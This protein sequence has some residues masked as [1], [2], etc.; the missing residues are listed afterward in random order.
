MKNFSFLWLVGLLAILS[1]IP[2]ITQAQRQIPPRWEVR[3]GMGMLPTFLKDHVS[4]QQLPLSVE[5]RYRPVRQI[6]LGF[7]AGR[8]VSTGQVQHFSGGEQVF[9]NT[10]SQFALRAAVHSSPWETW[11]LYG[12]LYLGYAH[13]QVD[14]QSDLSKSEMNDLPRPAARQGVLISGFLGTSVRLLDEFR[15]FGEVGYGL[16]L[17]TVGLSYRF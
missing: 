13:S 16:S 2:Q 6:S 5:L 8:S 12:G 9:R 4:T 14:Y 1:C 3:A 17:A 15:A 10:Y 11:E 7:L